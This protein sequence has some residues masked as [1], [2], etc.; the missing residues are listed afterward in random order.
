MQG[1]LWSCLFST[2]S[3]DL[4]E[5]CTSGPSQDDRSSCTLSPDRGTAMCTSH[6]LPSSQRPSLTP[7]SPPF[8]FNRRAQ[9]RPR[10]TADKL[11]RGDRRP[12]LSDTGALAVSPARSPSPLSGLNPRP[13]F[14]IPRPAGKGGPAEPS[15]RCPALSPKFQRRRARGRGGGRRAGRA[16][17]EG[18]PR[19]AGGKERARRGGG[20]QMEAGAE[21]TVSAAAGRPE[22]VSVS[23]PRRRGSGAAP[24]KAK[25]KGPERQ[26]AESRGAVSSRSCWCALPSC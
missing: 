15:K 10:P 3:R 18:R 4:Q 21:V 19:R 12:G 14:Q 23:V 22:R 16:G 20:A 11:G 26:G 2:S 17:W 6:L 24:T 9:G 25:L 8:P 5:P 13:L 7:R 1:C